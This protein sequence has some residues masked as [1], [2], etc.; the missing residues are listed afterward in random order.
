[1]KR[2]KIL[3]RLVPALVAISA[4]GALSVMSATAASAHKSA[5]KLTIWTWDVDQQ[6]TGDAAF[7]KAHRRSP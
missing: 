4:L 1:M 2:N 7:A 3:T 6:K 5:T